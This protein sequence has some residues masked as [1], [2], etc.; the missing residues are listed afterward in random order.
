MDSIVL[1]R[2]NYLVSLTFSAN[3]SNETVIRLT[4]FKFNRRTF[5]AIA[6]IKP[7]ERDNDPVT[8][9]DIFNL[10]LFYSEIIVNKC[11]DKT[12][13]KHGLVE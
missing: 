5:L 7:P 10:L 9:I 13:H 1:C 3:G 2:N 6:D 12:Q 4:P 11:P 8:R